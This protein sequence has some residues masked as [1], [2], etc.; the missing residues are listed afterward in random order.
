M[1]KIPNTRTSHE[2]GSTVPGLQSL[3]VEVRMHVYDHVYRLLRHAVVTRAIPPGTRIVEETLAAQFEVSRT[4]VARCTQKKSC[5]LVLLERVPVVSAGVSVVRSERDARA[6]WAE[7][8][9]FLEQ[10]QLRSPERLFL[11]DMLTGET[12]QRHSVIATHAT[13]SCS[14]NVSAYGVKITS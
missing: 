11:I 9:Q 2:L 10:V 14:I 1:A 4:P 5:M 6:L 8:L 13:D 12:S 3:S 7:S